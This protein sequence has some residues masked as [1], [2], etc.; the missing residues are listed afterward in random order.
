M[1]NLFKAKLE[2]LLNRLSDAQSDRCSNFCTA[3]K[4]RIAKAYRY[5]RWLKPVIRGLDFIIVRTNG[6]RFI[7]FEL[8]NI[9]NA[10]CVFC[11][12]PDMLKSGK[13]FT[14]MTKQTL[15][16]VSGIFSRFKGT[17]VSFTPTTGDTL[18]HP[19][20]DTFI[21][22]ILGLESV[23]RATMFTNAIE[24]DEDAVE[25]LIHLIRQDKKGKFSQIY[26]SLGGYNKTSYKQLYQVD[27]FDKV[28]ANIKHLMKR[29]IQERIPLGIHLHVKLEKHVKADKEMAN[30]VYN[31][32]GY[33]FVYISHSQ[34][35]FSNDAYKRNAL[36]DYYSIKQESRDKACA[37]L[38]KTRFAADGGIWADG[39][40]ISEMPGDDTLKLGDVK[41]DWETIESLRHNLIVNWEDKG[42]IPKP[43]KGCTMYRPRK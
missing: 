11:P 10:R 28:Q 43:C 1:I 21:S 19:E 41:S 30:S 6:N 13:T 42:E 24:L 23:G 29:L 39:C 35:F 14:H 17:L 4:Y 18:L 9:C 7:E 25:R 27:R 38:N 34:S 12:Y 16:A 22:S 20:W 5:F 31:P 36:I 2:G 37:Y 15:N 3:L 33:P 40:V 8:S 26:F 32:D